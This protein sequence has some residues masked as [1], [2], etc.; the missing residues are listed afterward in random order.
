MFLVTFGLIM[1]FT[2][3]PHA[4]NQH[5]FDLHLSG[6]RSF[7]ISD[8]Q[9]THENGSFFNGGFSYTL[10]NHV[11][12]ETNIGYSSYSQ[13]IT[14]MPDQNIPQSA[15]N[16]PNFKVLNV[17]ILLKLYISNRQYFTSP[18]LIFG[19]GRSYIL[20]NY[21]NN[22]S[23]FSFNIGLGMEFNISEQFLLLI[24]TQVLSSYME[25][26]S[27]VHVPAVLGVLYNL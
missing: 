7:I 20:N 22:I 3:Q 24:Q 8:I 12:L 18:Y 19:I 23:G 11:K 26:S 5:R 2:E 6:G 27:F 21:Q 16:Y 9:G 15:Y 10:L 25:N 4:Q 17:N 14:V 13:E 1:L